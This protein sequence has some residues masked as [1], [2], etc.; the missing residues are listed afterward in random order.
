MA[1]KKE[2]P[3]L[4][5]LRE[6]FEVDVDTGTVTRRV[7]RAH[8]ALAGDVVGTK[9]GKGYLH[10][11][12][13]GRFYRLHRISY[14]MHYGVDPGAHIDH[15]NGD[16]TD[17]RPSNLRPATNQQNAG[18]VTRMFRHNTSGYRGVSLNRK[19]GKWHAQIKL[20]GKQTYLGRFD[21]PEDAAEVYAAAADKHFGEF[22]RAH[23]G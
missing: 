4:S 13:E 22:A 20:F 21:T 12:I 16:R 7:T 23:R 10:V 18:N 19:T 17:N 15:I 3:P 5:F 11:H 1:A 6:L 9:D 8:N 2:L 14:Y